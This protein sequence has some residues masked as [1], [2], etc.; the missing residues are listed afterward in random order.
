MAN[1]GGGFALR[2]PEIERVHYTRRSLLVKVVDPE[3]KH[4]KDLNPESKLPKLSD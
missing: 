4:Q 1:V 2:R 3:E